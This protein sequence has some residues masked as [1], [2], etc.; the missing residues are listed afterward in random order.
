M[1]VAQDERRAGSQGGG[2]GIEV[3]GPSGLRPQHRDFDE[4]ASRH[5]RDVEERHIGRCRQHD[6]SVGRGE[7]GEHAEER[8]EDIA[9][10][11]DVA[12]GDPPAV[13]LGAEARSR[14]SQIGD[15]IG[16]SI[17][18][19]VALVDGLQRLTHSGGDPEVHLGDEGADG[20]GERRPL[21]AALRDQGF[22]GDGIEIGH[23]CSP[24]RGLRRVRFSR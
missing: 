4:L 7:M 14:G 11:F 21:A 12:D 23:L 3:E 24:L 6:R 20:V 19:E 18:V 22:L 9:G 10:R 17:A 1:R 8:G 2:D 15:G 5:A 16:G 13:A